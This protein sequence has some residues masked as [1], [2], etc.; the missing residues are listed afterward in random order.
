[1]RG[2]SL[3]TYRDKRDSSRTP[4][5]F[6]VARVAAPSQAGANYA[7][8]LQ[9]HAA[10]RLHWDFR[11]EIDGVLVSWAVPRG[12][13]VDPREK[14][15]AVQT[16]DHPIEYG[17]FEGIIPAGNYG[18]GAVILWDRGV[19]HTL[20]G[21]A[22]AEGLARGKLDIELQGEKLAGRWA[23]VRTKRGE[24][25][26]WLL[27]KKADGLPASPEPVVALPGSVL[28]GLTVE[29]LRDGVT[30]DETLAAMAAE[31]GAAR[32]A[33]RVSSLNP[34]L[35]ETAERAFSR[36]G[37][38]FE[39]KYDG[40]RVLV[41]RDDGE[42]RIHSRRGR[43]LCDAFPEVAAAAA[44]LPCRSFVLDGEIVATGEKE[45]GSFE[46]LQGRV[47]QTNPVTVARLAV[48]VPVVVHCFDL[49]AVAGYDLRALPLIER[50]ELLRRLLPVR[51]TFR[52]AD[53]VEGEGEALFAAATEHHL[54]GIVA[55]RADSPYHPGRRSRD[56]LKIKAP[57]TAD[58][59][60][61]GYVPGKGS[62]RSLGS[63]MLA[64]RDGTGLRYA[65]NAG[66]GLDERK[67]RDLLDHFQ[68]RR[69]EAPAF[70][71]DGVERPRDAV[72]VE[73]DLVAEVR[74]TEVTSA[75]V[76][77]QPVFERLRDEKEVGDCDERPREKNPESGIRNPE[78]ATT[79][80]EGRNSQ[81][82]VPNPQSAIRNRSIRNSSTSPQPPAPSPR[83]RLT[84]LDKVFW[85]VEGYTKRDLLAYY[86]AIWPHLA[87][88]LKDRPLVL[89]R[90]PDGI[91]G[92]SFF[93][94]N[95]PE[96]TP[97]WVE[98]CRIEDTEYFVC[99]EL[100][101]LL[102]VINTGCIP[103]HLW[104]ARSASI[105]R[106]DW[107]ILDLDPKGAPF[108][109]VVKVARHIH[110]ILE[111]LGAPHF[112]KTSGQ[113][114]L[115]VLLPLAA[116]LTHDQAKALAEVLARVV[117]SDL[118][119]I[120][121]VAR[122]LGDRGGKVYVDF[123]QN[124]FGKTIAGPYSVRPRPGAP[125]STPLVWSEVNGKLD[126]AKFT[127]RTVPRRAGKRSDP[128]AGALGPSIDVP[129]VLAAL[130]ERLDS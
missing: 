41:S 104:S 17:G 70:D 68:T 9:Q 77:R 46:E 14:R 97:E 30:R 5:P 16:E 79:L 63:L 90:Y 24:G 122:P 72:F 80:A 71:F 100:E 26:E 36:P 62:R 20:D 103:L 4:E 61:V 51:G 6:G 55:K 109:D 99:N 56:W 38:I 40:W 102:Y 47:G 81:S 130:E 87:P 118:P 12:P 57:R 69:R 32:R 65:G 13:S 89:T 110:S 111:P 3:D 120:A 88:Y 37:W 54:E 53:H 85:P 86:E 21:V 18:A 52:F 129:A 105:D 119:A 126:P 10:R 23:L 22:P 11:L 29:E 121:T 98:T 114:G 43:D 92:K 82:A 83:L 19:Y 48:E 31:A 34:M 73:P 112:L 28:S 8:V 91:E 128:F 42:V 101:T 113:D 39:L 50:K 2:R 106:P 108:S 66:S 25:K 94:K 7:F 93:Q 125:V 127:I 33:V 115:H 67:I 64:W 58:L 107:T 76:L 44:H 27:F 15:L 49:L 1:M 124:G 117:A 78:S 84:N 95:A 45:T 74:Y 59:A 116:T 75:G 96:F 60:V 35:A 123:L